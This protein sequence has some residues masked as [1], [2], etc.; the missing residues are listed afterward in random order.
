MNELELIEEVTNSI[1][2][3]KYIELLDRYEKELVYFLSK[4][5]TQDVF[6]LFNRVILFHNK[7]IYNKENDYE[8]YD[9][10]MH[11][12]LKMI[13]N[14]HIFYYYRVEKIG[15]QII[16]DFDIA[17]EKLICKLRELELIYYY[18][19]CKEV[20][21]GIPLE[22]KRFYQDYFKSYFF[23]LPGIEEREFYEF[24]N[25][26]TDMIKGI[27]EDTD[28][29]SS[30][31]IGYILQNFEKL[32]YNEK[33]LWNMLRYRIILRK[34]GVKNFSK[35]KCFYVYPINLVKKILSLNRIEY[36]NFIEKYFFNIT[37]RSSNSN[38]KRRLI[39]CLAS[40]D[41]YIGMLDKKYIYFPRN[42]Y[43]KYRW[44]NK[45]WRSKEIRKNVSEGKTYKS[46]KHEEEILKILNNAFGEKNVHNNLYIKREKGKYAEKDFI[47]TFGK[48]VISVEA[49]SKL[50]PEPRLDINDG[51]K[52]LENKLQESIISAAKQSYEIK[53]AIENKKAFFYDSN[54]AKIS[55]QVLN[56]NTYE[57][58]NFIQIAITYEEFLNL[59]TNPECITDDARGIE[60]WVTDIKTLKVILNDTVLKGDGLRF[61]DYI[62]KRV[63]GYG[64]FNVQS[65][66]ELKTYNLYKEM[67]FIFHHDIR[68]KGIKIN[69]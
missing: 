29:K 45:I 41:I 56:L 22:K 2:N 44:F 19:P 30:L 50:L 47:V 28:F 54:N 65:G 11:I 46:K 38:I 27:I 13:L 1:A 14:M 37:N 15:M 31:K 32:I 21:E 20:R 4:Y 53:K 17:T 55:K 12:S 51:L 49:K 9:R 58:C 26:N 5:V 63:K 52:E 34:A 67:P 36:E 66:E 39:D 16:G 61:I 33:K 68:G 42:Y 59:E 24:L 62:Q 18:Y 25:K 6:I 57:A 48:Y 23:D 69:I 10:N 8:K 64:L 60:F 7:N 3:G 35:Y 43:W 40:D